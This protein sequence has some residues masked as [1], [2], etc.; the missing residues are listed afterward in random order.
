MVVSE[1]KALVDLVKDAV[2][3]SKKIQNHS[4]ELD[5]KLTTLQKCIHDAYTQMMELRSEN[6]SL[7]AKVSIAEMPFDDDL[8]TYY[9]DS[10]EGRAYFCQR[11]ADADGKLCRMKL[12][13]FSYACTVCNTEYQNEHLK[14]ARR[15]FIR[16]ERG[17]S[18]P[19]VN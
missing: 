10:Q 19:W 12:G 13:K 8:G 2:E 11:C 14:N 16:A 7:K 17:N 9:R 5:A 1:I 15:D 4:P 3:T 18:K 6:D